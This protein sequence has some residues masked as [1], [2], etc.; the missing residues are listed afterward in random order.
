MNL[1]ITNLNPR[2]AAE[3]HCT[4]H[5]NKMIIET[6]QM[7][8]TA[9]RLLDGQV[10]ADM[11]GLYKSTHKNHPCSVWVRESSEQYQWAYN[12]YLHLCLSYARDRGISHASYRLAKSLETPP[13]NIPFSTHFRPIIAATP[14]YKELSLHLGVETA[15]QVYLNHKFKNWMSREVPMKF[16][17]PN[18]NPSWLQRKIADYADSC[19]E[20]LPHVYYS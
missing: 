9:H 17:W 20:G 16:Y 1:F 14:E 5:R 13:E 11:L 8:C 3:E 10:K 6:A 15:Y 19:K 18:G 12:L 4:V 7:L 2:I